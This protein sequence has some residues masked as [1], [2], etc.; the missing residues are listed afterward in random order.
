MMGIYICGRP[1]WSFGILS[2][3]IRLY[4]TTID[5]TYYTDGGDVVFTL[6]DLVDDS[7]CK[8]AGALIKM[9]LDD[10]IVY[11]GHIKKYETRMKV[12]PKYQCKKLRRINYEK[13]C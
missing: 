7:H 13:G 12:Q 8:E 6:G 2:G 11:N 1:Y 5:F 4:E 9:V 10:I 3:H